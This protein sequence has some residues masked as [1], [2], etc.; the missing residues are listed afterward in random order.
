MIILR[1]V[2]LFGGFECLVFVFWW[3]WVVW[4]DCWLLV[5]L[6]WLLRTVV[7]PFLVN[8]VRCGF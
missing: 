4:F 7:V 3:F 2:I 5:G 1:F 8:L 6:R